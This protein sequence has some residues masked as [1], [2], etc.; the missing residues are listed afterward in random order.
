MKEY[1]KKKK[2]MFK[3]FNDII[4]SGEIVIFGTAFFESYPIYELGKRYLMTHAVYNRS[5]SGMTSGEALEVLEDCVISAKP[6]KLFLALGE[7]DT[8]DEKLAENYRK[9]LERISRALPNTKVYALSVPAV[10]TSAEKC[11]S[12]IGDV[13]RETNTEFI[14]LDYSLESQSLFKCLSLYMRDGRLN[15]CEAFNLV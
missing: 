8:A 14:E 3:V 6:G 15:M 7:H 2:E 4:L 11:N 9:I 12:I 13:C 1:V 10:S 5:I